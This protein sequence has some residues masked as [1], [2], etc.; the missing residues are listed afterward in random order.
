M[1]DLSGVNRSWPISAAFCCAWSMFASDPSDAIARSRHGD[2]RLAYLSRTEHETPRPAEETPPAMPLEDNNSFDGT[3]MFT[4]SGCPYTGSLPARI[5]GGKIIVRGGSG[6]VDPDGTLHFGGRR[7][8][9]DLDRSRT[10]VGEYRLRNIQSIRRLYRPV[11]CDQAG[12]FARTSAVGIQHAAGKKER[13]ARSSRTAF[14]RFHSAWKK[15]R[16]AL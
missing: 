6:Q 9:H 2:T 3:W 5:I 10:I 8:R 11:D 16:I 15:A 12:K 7:K 4:S 1:N 14:G 13:G